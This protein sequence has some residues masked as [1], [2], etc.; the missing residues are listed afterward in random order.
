MFLTFNIKENSPTTEEAVA[1]FLIALEQAKAAGA[2]VVKIIHGY[3]SS[4]KGGVILLELKKLL[5]I[6]VRQ[7]KI[8]DY[9]SGAEW[10]IANPKVFNLITKCP[11][12][13]LDEDLRKNN[14]GITII[15]L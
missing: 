14:I 12:C 9:I 2:K 8:K 13:A 6:F 11:P 7:K 4:G 10:N 5:P 1:N 15:V 3:G